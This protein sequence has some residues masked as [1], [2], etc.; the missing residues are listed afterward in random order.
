MGIS[1][2][3]CVLMD[4]RDER[5]GMYRWLIVMLAVFGGGGGG[6]SLVSL[7]CGPRL[8]GRRRQMKNHRLATMLI[9]KR[10]T[11]TPRAISAPRGSRPPEACASDDDD[12]NRSSVVNV[13]VAVGK[14]GADVRAVVGASSRVEK[15]KEVDFKDRVVDIEVVTGLELVV[16]GLVVDEV[17]DVVK[18]VVEELEEVR[19]S[20]QNGVVESPPTQVCPFAQQ[21]EPH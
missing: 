6:C 9:T 7:A 17:D 16:K 11:M 14:K 10:G 2:V 21:M 3:L 4:S 20:L 1:I 19:W 5:E 13:E 15:S 18:T 8:P 12:G